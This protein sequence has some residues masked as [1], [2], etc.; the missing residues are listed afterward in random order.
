[1]TD[2]LAPTRTDSISAQFSV[3]SYGSNAAI[4]DVEL[5]SSVRNSAQK[6]DLYYKNSLEVIPNPTLVFGAAS[7]PMMFHYSEVYNLDTAQ[8]YVIKTQ[9]IARMA[10]W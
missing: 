9:V 3:R 1:V 4:S 8:T 10:K 6:D 5:C 2:S 7:H